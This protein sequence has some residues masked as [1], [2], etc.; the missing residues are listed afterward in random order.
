MRDENVA[1][2]KGIFTTKVT[3]EGY[4]ICETKEGGQRVDAALTLVPSERQERLGF[5]NIL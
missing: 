1:D 2:S 5:Q 3:M 4:G